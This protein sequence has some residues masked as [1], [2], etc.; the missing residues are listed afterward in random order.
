MPET[1][2]VVKLRGFV[3]DMHGQVIESV[4][5]LIRVLLPA[6]R[7]SKVGPPSGRLSWFGLARR[8][9]PIQMELRLQQIDPQ[10]ANL[11]RVDALFRPG[12]STPATD[13]QWRARCVTIFIEIRGY[14]MG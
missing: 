12:D 3:R 8:N 9:G 10:R 5:G 6:D 13:P 1:V 4:P 2:A 7:S 11:L 14:L